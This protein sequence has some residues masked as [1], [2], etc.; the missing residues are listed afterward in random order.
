MSTVSE[1]F[2]ARFIKL[3]KGMTCDQV[4]K[5]VKSLLKD[6]FGGEKSMNDSILTLEIRTISHTIEGELP[7]ISNE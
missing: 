1:K 2:S 5:Q 6:Y 7:K 4:C 3:D